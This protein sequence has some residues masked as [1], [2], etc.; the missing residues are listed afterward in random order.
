MFHSDE[1]EYSRHR[2]TIATIPRSGG[3]RRAGG[4]RGDP[5]DDEDAAEDSAT[6][7]DH[8]PIISSGLPSSADLR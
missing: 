5:R 3:F 1:S 7:R 2:R 4:L 8:A 6:T